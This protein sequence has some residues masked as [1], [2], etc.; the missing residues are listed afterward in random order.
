MTRAASTRR[1]AAFPDLPT[2]APRGGILGPLTALAGPLLLPAAAS[3]ATAWVAVL[4]HGVFAAAC[5]ACALRS[6][7][8]GRPGAAGG[9]GLWFLVCTAGFVGGLHVG[10][11]TQGGIAWIPAWLVVLAV[12]ALAGPPLAAAYG[13]AGARR[14]RKVAVVVARRRRA[15]GWAAQASPAVG[16]SAG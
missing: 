4:G 3:S 6:A 12:S 14:R 8:I 11:W 15:P 5:V 16:N 13:M 2:R 7:A 9:W 10:S 1:G